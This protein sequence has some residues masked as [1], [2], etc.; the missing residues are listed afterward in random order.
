MDRE[1]G[2]VDAEVVELEGEDGWWREQGLELVGRVDLPEEERLEIERVRME[3]RMVGG[4]VMAVIY[5]D[6]VI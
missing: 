1:R 6:R 4:V 2:G 5:V 3:E